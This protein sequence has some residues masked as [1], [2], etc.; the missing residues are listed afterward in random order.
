M[1]RNGESIGVGALLR[2]LTISSLLVPKVVPNTLAITL[3]SNMCPLCHL[4][5]RKVM[6]QTFVFLSQMDMCKNVKFP[7]LHMSKSSVIANVLGTISR[8]FRHVPTFSFWSP[9]MLLQ[10]FVFLSQMDIGKSVK[11]P[12][13]H[14]SKSS[15]IANVLGTIYGSENDK[16][17]TS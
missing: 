3:L 11:F 13:L 5:V 8:R 7:F 2:K 4:G 1:A 14:M 16:M 10:P 17:C 6:L 15:V 9:K 12:F